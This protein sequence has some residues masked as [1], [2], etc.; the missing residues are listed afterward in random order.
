MTHDNDNGIPKVRRG[1]LGWLEKNMRVPLEETVSQ[2]LGRSWEIRQEDDYSEFAYHRCAVVSDGTAAVFFKFSDAV[3]AER[4]FEV[5]LSDLL[6]LS[7]KAGVLIPEPIGIVRTEAGWLL[8]MKALEA[9]ERGDRQW[10]DIGRTLAQIHQVT[11]DSHGSA[12]HG[13]CGPLFHDN[14]PSDNWAAFFAERRMRPFPR[15]AAVDPKKKKP[16]G[17]NARFLRKKFF[18]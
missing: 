14:T 2:H 10:R 13:F 3:D 12:A 9:V 1:P 15:A 18:I 7:E 17:I 4:Q 6:T 11:G 16:D 8:I 5:E